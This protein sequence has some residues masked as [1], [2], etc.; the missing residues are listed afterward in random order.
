TLVEDVRAYRIPLI[1]WKLIQQRKRPP[2]Q[3]AQGLDSLEILIAQNHR[4]TNAKPVPGTRFDTPPTPAARKRPLGN[5]KKPRRGR[6]GLRTVTPCRPQ[7]RS[8]HLGHEIRRDLRIT[9]TAQHE[10]QERPLITLVEQ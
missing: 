2:I 10:H 9:R 1:G 5:R 8:K 7:G 4:V 3:A 6:R